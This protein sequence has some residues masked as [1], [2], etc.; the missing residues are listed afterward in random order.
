MTK[1]DLLI[2]YCITELVEIIAEEKNIDY[3]EAMNLLYNSN[4]FNKLCNLKTELYKEGSA[5]LYELF[6][7]ELGVNN[8]I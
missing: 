6:K 4:F 5:Y 8:E 1:Q 2:E 3:I 7:E